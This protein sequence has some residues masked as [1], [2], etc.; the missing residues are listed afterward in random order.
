M[1][2]ELNNNV[3]GSL[4]Q[5]QYKGNSQYSKSPIFN[6]HDY[7][8]Q[9]AGYCSTENSTFYLEN[10]IP[11]EMGRRQVCITATHHNKQWQ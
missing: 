7:Y 4:Q 1:K 11:E 2:A 8:P 3:F 6:H 9:L 10:N 5:I